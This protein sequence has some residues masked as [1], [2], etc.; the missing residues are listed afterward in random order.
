M[1][2]L[3]GRLPDGVHNTVS[4]DHF[5][6]MPYENFICCSPDFLPPPVLELPILVLCMCEGETSFFGSILHSCKSQGL[7][8]S[9]FPLQENSWA[10]KI[11][12]SP[13]LC[14]LGRGVM[15][16]KSSCSCYPFQCIQTRIVFCCSTV[17]ELLFWKCG[18]PH[19]SSHLW[20]MPNS[21]FSRGSWTMA[22][23]GCT[24]SQATAGSTASTEV[25]L[26]ITQYT[27]G[28]DPSWVPWHIMLDPTEVLLF[29]DGC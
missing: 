3:I 6:L 8:C 13:K 26:P 10:G 7:T 9:P 17:L 19:R 12:L 1:L 5:S 27:G 14:C 22:E 2:S 16:V 4:R 21:L 28:R 11:S 15:W 24:S 25:C 29:L 18:L 23:R 20:V